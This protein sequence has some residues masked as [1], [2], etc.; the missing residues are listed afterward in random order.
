RAS[1]E[2]RARRA[3]RP[4]RAA[5]SARSRPAR[6][7]VARRGRS[8]AAAKAPLD[9][10]ASEGAALRA[11]LV[12][13]PPRSR[14]AVRGLRRQP[15]ALPR[16]RA[17]ARRRRRGRRVLS[18]PA[19]NPVYPAETEPFRREV[20]EWAVAEVARVRA[21]AAGDDDF[22][23]RWQS[24]LYATGW[25]CP[26]WPER[27][28]GR[29]LS[30]L[31]AAI[32]LD[33]MMA[34]GAPIPRPTGGE[35]LVGPTI[36][37]WGT[38]E[39]RARFLPRIARG[40]ETWCQGFSEPEAGSD[41]ASLTTTA[42]LDGDELVLHGRKKWTSEGDEADLMFVLAVTDPDNPRRHRAITYF[43]LPMDQ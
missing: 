12:E 23:A 18:E 42:T 43:L 34:A 21:E 25:A 15:A 28:G 19:V 29:G 20:R 36:L 24:L 33:E 11:H 30:T 9:V 32:A 39:Q 1:R 13:Q 26:T 5:R 37:Q 16:R 27:Y 38:D 31:Q 40:E 2:H 7:G 8:R 41:L 10:Q 6:D 3:D 17:A 14:I 4:G 22:R 35:L